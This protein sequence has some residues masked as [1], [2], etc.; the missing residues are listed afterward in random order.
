MFKT[1]IQFIRHSLYPSKQALRLRLAPL[2]AYML[3]SLILTLTVTVLDYIVLQPDFFWPMW[4]FLH[5][6]AIFFF[7]MGFVAFS[8]ILV[9]LVT[10]WLTKRTWPYR[11]AWPYAVAMTLVPVLS[12]I[13]LYHIAP[14]LTWVGVLLSLVYLIVPLRHIPVKSK[15][16]NKPDNARLR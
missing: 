5:G 15:S 11:Q 8:A 13:V 4:L 6:F 7:Y 16:S 2:H 1:T 9:Q 3:A 14:S 10:R 12:L